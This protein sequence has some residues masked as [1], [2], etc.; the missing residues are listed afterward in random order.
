MF[1]ASG[2]PG[3]AGEQAADRGVEHGLPHDALSFRSQAVHGKHRG[4]RVPGGAVRG[5]GA[6]VPGAA[7]LLQH[8]IPTLPPSHRASKRGQL[9]KPTRGKWAKKF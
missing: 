6:Q 2:V 4:Q 5:G 9:W 7:A 8:P 3:D 1:L